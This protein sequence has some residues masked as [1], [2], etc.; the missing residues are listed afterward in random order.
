M[1]NANPREVA[2]D[3]RDLD[4]TDVPLRV[5]A[6]IERAIAALES[7]GEPAAAT[8]PDG[9]SL[10]A[11]DF[12]Y[13]DVSSLM[14]GTPPTS[15]CWCETCRPIMLMD[16]RMVVCPTC[17]NK[18]CPHA[19]DHRNACS[20]SN[21]PGQKGSS[22]EH[23]RPWCDTA[24]PTVTQSGPPGADGADQGGPGGEVREPMA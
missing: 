1:P 4:R 24:P 14:D 3:L 5:R 23:V 17:G 21:E 6:A 19:T 16:M 22:W 2:Q 8:L 15:E 9:L 10:A 12:L 18:R 13:P 7:V 20:G 11:R